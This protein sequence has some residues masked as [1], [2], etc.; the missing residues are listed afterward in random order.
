VIAEDRIERE[1]ERSPAVV[2]LATLLSTAARI[3]P[4]LLRAVRL[5]LLPRTHA[6][7]EVDLWFS[8][9]VEW[10][11]VDGITFYAD[12]Q[13]LLRERLATQTAAADHAG[14]I[15]GYYHE[16][17]SPALRLEERLAQLYVMGRPP[18]EI[19][20]ELWPALAALQDPERS[21]LLRWAEQAV[22]RL[23]APLLSTPTGWVFEQLARE[24][25]EPRE[26][27]PEL[28][29]LDLSVLE[30][31][32][33]LR[34]GVR[35]VGTRLDLGTLDD[36]APEIAVPATSPVALDVL[37][38]EHRETV[39]VPASREVGDGPVRVVTLLGDV[40]EVPVGGV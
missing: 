17:M 15:I 40:F 26:P 29:G 34:I 11:G 39:T 35:R 32:P 37:W 27:P 18:A 36:D 9:L 5:S 10:A 2:E 20:P 25:P 7:T 38:D 4:E 8:E 33:L 14:A 19:E 6:S 13:A 21:E 16:S 28:A 22:D 3:E 30:A 12:V 31:R 1:L 24:H 23:P